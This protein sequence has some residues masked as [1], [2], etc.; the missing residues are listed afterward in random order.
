MSTTVASGAGVPTLS[1]ELMLAGWRES[2][3]GGATLTFWLPDSADL[4]TFRALTVRKGGKAG[5]RFMAALA[6]LGDDDQPVPCGDGPSPAAAP[7]A[8]PASA[9]PPPC[10]HAASEIK[11]GPLARLAGMWCTEPAFQRWIRQAHGEAMVR[12]WGRPEVD[13]MAPAEFARQAILMLCDV[14]SRAALDH[15][16]AAEDTFHTLVRRPFA[17]HMARLKS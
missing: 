13:A 14:D 4:D 5:Q 1:L 15:D 10:D 16:E 2:N 12:E 7:A 11:G 6:L 3:T 9:P 17:Q 8:A